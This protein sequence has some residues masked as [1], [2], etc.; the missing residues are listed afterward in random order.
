MLI[1]EGLDVFEPFV[2]DRAIDLIIREQ[3]PDGPE[4]Y[5]VQVKSVKG[6]NRIVGVKDVNSFS[7]NYLVIVHYR[8]DKKDDEI[9]YLTKPQ[10]IQH[11]KSDST[12]GDLVLNKA[13]REIY[14]NQTLAKLAKIIQ[15]G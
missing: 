9:F 12:W 5:E 14:K 4:F 3:K 2:D 8:H 10:I 11:H 7:L 6:Y 15:G 1:R 13:E